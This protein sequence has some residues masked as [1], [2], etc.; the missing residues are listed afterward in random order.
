[1][2]SY[3]NLLSLQPD[4]AETR[5]RIPPSASGAGTNETLFESVACVA[6]PTACS[7]ADCVAGGIGCPAFRREAIRLLVTITDEPNQCI[8][9]GVSTAADAAGRLRAADILFVGVDAD[10]A[11][12]PEAHLK[13]LARLSGSIDAMGMPYYAAGTEASVTTA[14]T[15]AIRAIA[16]TRPLF[17]SVEATDE[18][19]DALQFIDHLE[20]DVSGTDGCTAIASVADTDGDGLPDAFPNLLP[21]T[22]VC[23]E[24]VARDNDRVEVRD[25]PVV[26]RARITVRGDDSVLDARTVYFLVPPVI[27]RP[28]VE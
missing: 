7:G 4:S 27:D 3:R 22:P 15:D 21:G 2:N 19:G 18:E 23:W 28:I 9:C 10:A 25:R 5:R 24:V 8:S 12:S 11:S 17:V 13:Q 16:E 1:V 6:D 14:V 20:I 26:F